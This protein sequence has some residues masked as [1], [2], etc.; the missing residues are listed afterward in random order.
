GLPAAKNAAEWIAQ[1]VA[2]AE[3]LLWRK[4]CVECHTLNAMAGG[5]PVVA[6][7]A[8]TPRWMK[9][10]MFNHRAHQMLDCA[11]CH[12]QAMQ[13]EKTS[14]VL[15][16]GIDT[17]RRCHRTGPEAAAANCAECHLYHDRS[18][19]KL[20]NGGMTISVAGGAA[21]P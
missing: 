6:E 2:D 3:T 21:H 20:V 13:S 17:C 16:P 19:L 15:L 7:A 11:Q 18:K 1:R 12:A 10:A 8:I 9:H 14:D 5:L 4:S